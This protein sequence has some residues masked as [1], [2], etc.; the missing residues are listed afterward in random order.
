MAYSKASVSAPHIALR[1]AQDKGQDI[2]SDIANRSFV[3]VTASR[4]V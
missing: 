3:V 2:A 1:I 4:S